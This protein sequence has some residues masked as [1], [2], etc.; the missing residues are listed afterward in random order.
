LEK[1]NLHLCIGRRLGNETDPNILNLLQPPNIPILLYPGESNSD[2][3]VLSLSQAKV[4][5]QQRKEEMK[6]KQEP[7]GKIVVLGLDATWKYA[8]EMHLANQKDNHYPSHMLQVSLQAE[9]FPESFRPRRFDIR[10]TPGDNTTWMSTAECIAWVLSQLESKPDL[11][12]TIM[13]PLDEMVKKWNSF[14][15]KP[16]IR[17]QP[18]R[19]KQKR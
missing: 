16:K 11:F 5:L 4:Q 18:P 17:D 10:T 3:Q 7:S 12:S 8:R 19:K 1:K 9:D 14:V 13:R 15:Q 2:V 6:L